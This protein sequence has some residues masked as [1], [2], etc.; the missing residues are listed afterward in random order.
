MGGAL[1]AE[2]TLKRHRQQ[3]KLCLKPLPPEKGPQAAGSVTQREQSV[4]MVVKGRHD[5]AKSLAAHL[6]SLN[7]SPQRIMR[8]QAVSVN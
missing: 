7:P 8:F 5:R 3:G 6:T 4:I 1:L 2:V